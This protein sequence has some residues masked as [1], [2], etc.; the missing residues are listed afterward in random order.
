MKSLGFVL[1]SSFPRAPLYFSGYKR[2]ICLNMSASSKA[3][4]LLSGVDTASHIWSSH[5]P[6][7]GG[8]P[9]DNLLN[10]SSVTD[11]LNALDSASIRNAVI[12]Q[13]INYKFD[14]ELLLKSIFDCPSNSVEEITDRLSVI[15]LFDP[16]SDPK[17]QLKS[18]SNLVS[19]STLKLVGIRLNPYLF[20]NETG[21]SG[22]WAYSRVA[23]DLCEVCAAMKLPIGIMAFK[24]MR[25]QMKGMKHLLEKYPQ[26]T[27]I[28]DHFGFCAGKFAGNGSVNDEWI[29]K[30]F[31]ELCKDHKTQVYVKLSA[32]F[33]NANKNESDGHLEYD[34]LVEKIKDLKS[35]LGENR[36]LFGSDFPFVLE[37]ED[38]YAVSY[39]NHIELVRSILQ[40]AECNLE[41]VMNS[42]ARNLFFD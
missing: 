15:A 11:L 9:P 39:R 12:V 8:N 3:D 14:H 18:I 20:P 5:G 35:N 34:H 16:S 36:L 32:W 21:E 41:I 25:S 4:H 30:D 33:R 6:F 31:M 38:D 17:L 28:F 22:E 40:K 2:R 37:L 1:N 26:C 29:W 27:W 19:N 7:P 10:T 23:S 24:G 42:N 13:P